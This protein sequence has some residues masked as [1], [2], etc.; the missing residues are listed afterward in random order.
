VI[1]PDGTI[2]YTYTNLNPDDH[3]KNALTALKDWEAKNKQ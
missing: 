2:I 3:V 1:A